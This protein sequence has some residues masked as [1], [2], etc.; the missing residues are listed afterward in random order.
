VSRRRSIFAGI[1]VFVVV[2][3]VLVASATYLVEPAYRNA[4]LS[5]WDPKNGYRLATEEYAQSSDPLVIAI[6]MS[7]G[8]TRA[9]AFA[10]GVLEELRDTEVVIDG[11]PR[12][13]LDEVDFVSGVSGGSFTA[14]YYALFGERIFD[15]FEPSFLERNVQMALLFKMLYPTN[16]FRLF[17]ARFNRTDLAA[18]FYNDEIFNG[19]TF[20]DIS[21][22]GG[23]KT[24]I[25]ATN[26][27]TVHPFLFVQEQFD[28]ICSDLTSCPV[29]R[30]VAASAAVPVAFPPLVL[31][32][33]AGSCG[34]PMPEWLRESLDTPR[35]LSVRKG[36]NAS[37]LASYLDSNVRRYIH[38]L[39]G[40]ISD[41]LG[42]RNPF[43]EARG[44]AEERVEE[45][46]DHEPLVARE[47]GRRVV[48]IVVNAQTEPAVSWGLVDAAPSVPALL[49]TITDAQIDRH[50]AETLDVYRTRVE[51][52]EEQADLAGSSFDF[53]LI[54]VSFFAM[55]DGEERDYL[56][57]IP[58]TLHL[59]PA[60]VDRL[61]T[62]ARQLLRQ[63]AEF[64]KL[65][66]ELSKPVQS[67]TQ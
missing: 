13:L 28:F 45:Y 8:G 47:E 59:D 61:R 26:L 60:D 9:A 21:K 42:I 31:R 3:I 38:L 7:G 54:E 17:S 25:F 5:T 22:R 56:N 23:P 15:D 10:Y 41:N 1:G 67:S 20:D 16:W 50:S 65:R 27:S 55:P 24:I 34:F 43:R 14:A 33:H 40:G 12:R 36:I 18:E 66:I 48:H 44:T 30:A 46:L 11:A 63:S 2:F 37:I 39:D 6:S 29:A 57:R 49:G 32:N 64:Q 52:W 4:P 35:T 51:R 53:Y 62:A 58:T 19:A